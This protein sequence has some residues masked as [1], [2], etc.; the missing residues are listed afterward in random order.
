[1][2]GTAT[3]QSEIT[4]RIKHSEFQVF[5]NPFTDE[6]TIRSNH[7][8][9]KQVC[10]YDGMGQLVLKR[11]CDNTDHVRL[12]VDL[13]SGIYLLVVKTKSG[14]MWRERMIGVPDK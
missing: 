9:L 6:I 11:Q 1:L 13:P 7:S 8:D 12:E 3:V 5:P 14:Q 10:I 4:N 2:V